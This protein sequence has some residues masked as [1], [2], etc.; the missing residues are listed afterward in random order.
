MPSSLEC[1]VCNLKL[2]KHGHLF[3]LG[4][5]DQYIKIDVID[6]REYFGIDY[7]IEDFYE[8]DY[9]ND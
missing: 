2:S 6:P 8:P 1:I 9:G 7:D 5:G 4:L 3:H